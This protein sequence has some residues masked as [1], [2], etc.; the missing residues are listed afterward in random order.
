MLQEV[1]NS[2]KSFWNLVQRR[3]F[4]ELALIRKRKIQLHPKAKWQ[5]FQRWIIKIGSRTLEKL[6]PVPTVSLP[7]E[8]KAERVIIP[9]ESHLLLSSLQILDVQIHGSVKILLVEPVYPSMIPFA[10]GVLAIYVI[11]L[12][13]IRTLV[14]GWCVHLNLVRETTVVHLAILNVL[15][16]MRRWGLL[17]LGSWCS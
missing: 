12:M 15:F 2:F 1:Q 7:P 16:N 14:F 3:N 8:S 10:E 11:I 6:L 4:F 13:I 9:P 5:K 17:I